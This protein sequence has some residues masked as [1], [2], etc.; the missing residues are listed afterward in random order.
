MKKLSASDLDNLCLGSMVLGSGGG[1]NPTYDLSMAKQQFEDFEPACLVDLESIAEDAFVVPIAFMGAPLV[2]KERIPSGRELIGLLNIIEETTK[3]KVTHLL[4]AEIGGAN[5][6]TALTLSAITGIPVIDGDMIGRAFPELQMSSCNLKG[7]SASPCFIIDCLDNKAIIYGNSGSDVERLCRKMTVEMGSS[8]AISLYLM[9]GKQCKESII[10]STMSLAM[11]IGKAMRTNDPIGGLIE[12][13]DGEILGSGVISDIDQVIKDG[14][15]TGSFTIT[16][17]NEKMTVYYQNE[18][19]MVYKNGKSI[20]TTPDIIIP[21]EQETGL[22]ITSES[23]IFGLRVTLVKIAGPDIW[24][25]EQGLK[26]VGP[27][28]FGFT[29]NEEEICQKSMS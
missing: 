1:G 25:T 16:S 3:R 9:T 26:Y 15:L 14:F 6:F 21:L 5:A 19:L 22:P 28:Y 4:S 7:I 11:K 12:A 29:E 10:P 13:T 23:L 20:A 24:K 17:F 27:N 18:Y 2:S 8:T